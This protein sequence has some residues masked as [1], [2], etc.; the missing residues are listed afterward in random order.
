[1]EKVSISKAREVAKQILGYIPEKI[2]DEYASYEVNTGMIKI[3]IFKN[4]EIH[5]KSSRY[6]YF[7]VHDIDY[8][9]AA[10][11]AQIFIQNECKSEIKLDAKNLQ[12]IFFQYAKENY[13]EL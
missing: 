9:G 10:I 2:T 5:Y 8:N 7:K 4:I 3:S 13:L 11:T 6:N 1:M 12:T